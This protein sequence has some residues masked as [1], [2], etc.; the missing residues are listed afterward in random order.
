MLILAYI[1]SITMMIVLPV[2]LAAGLRR[3]TPA[4]W[5]LF[6]IGSLTFIVSQAVHLPLNEWLADLGWLPGKAN[7]DLPIWR[8]ALTLGLT[9]GLCEEL[10]RAGG[11][12]LLQRFKPFWMHLPD[13]IMLGLGHGG[14][15]SMI[16]GGILTAATLSSLLS[17]KGAD[18]TPLNLTPEQLAVLKI[19]LSALESP[20]RAALPLL[21]RLLAISAHVVFS[22]LVWRAFSRRQ[23]QRDWY[24]LVIAILYHAL[25]DAGA[26]WL[27]TRN[28]VQ[29]YLVELA[30]ALVLIPGWV[31]AAWLW[32]S[33]HQAHPKAAS[34]SGSRLGEDWAGFWIALQKELRQLWRTRRLLAMVAVFI[35]FGMGSPLLAKFTPEMLG[36]IEGAEM[37]KDL[38]P[39]PTAGDAMAQYIKNLT[40]FAF[41]LAVLMG[42]GAVVGEKER[43]VAQMILSKPMPRWA[44]ISS[45]FTAQALMYLVGF[46]LAG[47]GAY[48]YTL[49]L[50][51]SLDFNGFALL[52]GLLLL[53]LL[54]FVGLSLVGSTL[55]NSTASAGGIGLVLSVALLLAGNLPRY[56][57]LLP[58][59]LV[60]WA[61]LAGM[62]SAG[63]E[64]SMPGAA[65]FSGQ[66]ISN[67]GAAACA[68]VFIVMSLVFSVGIF[69]Q[70]EL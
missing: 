30:F 38:I 67:G 48:Y 35:V 68:L 57:Q 6:S 31:W 63:V 47:L 61:T 22:L 20:W 52:N 59:G 42:M 41:I 53:W 11:Y 7:S 13:A 8:N 18:L 62:Q 51:G 14:I 46:I 25:V 3:V 64:A 44:F 9:A 24:Y 45:K 58:G 50:F 5:L 56:G 37:F 21:E 65:T 55:G 16:F 10:A 66:M 12:A 23:F 29:P 34:T 17:V 54:V 1:I 39:T 28:P 70:Q 4:A 33:Y 32:R 49:I 2:V 43:G 40:Q 60:G 26:V 19:Q 36:M 69:E 15:E 27:I